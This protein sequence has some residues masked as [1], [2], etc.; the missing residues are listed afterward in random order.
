MGNEAYDFERFERAK[1]KKPEDVAQPPELRVVK[2]RQDQKG[3][4]N[5]FMIYFALMVVTALFVV[6]AV[7]YN[8]VRLTEL[9]AQYESIQQDYKE[10]EEAGNR[11]EVALEEKISLRTVEE[12]ATNDLKMAKTEEYQIEYVDLGSESKIVKSIKPPEG[13]TGRIKSACLRTLEY[14]EK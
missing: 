7:I 4:D 2:S 14:I 11:M 12:K 8:H 1:Y 3:R 10:L 13:V 9:T 5:S 6:A